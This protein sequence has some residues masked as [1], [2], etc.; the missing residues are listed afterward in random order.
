MNRLISLRARRTFVAASLGLLLAH[1]H[2]ALS[3]AT[4]VSPASWVVPGDGTPQQRDP[5][6]LFAELATHP[7]VLLGERHDNADHHRWQLHTIAGLYALQPDLVIGF[8]MFPRRVQ[9]ALDQWV[10]G[11]LSEDEFLKRSEWNR[12]WGVDARPYMPIFEFARLHR[13][14]MLALNVE[15]DLVARVGAVG[16]A[17]IPEPEREGVSDP[18]APSTGYREA[19]YESY[20]EHLPKEAPAR[21]RAEPDYDDPAFL[22]FVESMQLWDRAMAQA[23]AQRRSG[24]A[25][26]L[27]VAIMGSGHLEEGFGVP[28]QLRDLGVAEPAVLL[29][30]DVDDDCSTLTVGLAD[31][32]FGLPAASTATPDR[33]RLGV[34]L[35][36]GD[37]S[38]VVR[39][40]VKGSVAEQAGMHT[41]DV[42]VA[43]AGTPVEGAGDIINAVRQ[44]APGT[45]LP[46]TVK[47]GGE[48]L[49]LVARFP[50]RR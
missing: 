22:R 20:L 42:I 10:V 43:V 41:G 25:P 4:C 9:K 39:D 14:P 31:A 18:A 2:A 40:V 47:R 13:V 32:V 37:G 30:W 36:G 1:S 45:W 15:R 23:I 33:P 27:V 48:S 12:V 44:Q 35:D 38:V 49:E 17:G 6:A 16:W 7:V 50:P 3:S 26:P 29:P 34:M 5:R 46:M 19:L 24:A 28:H 11:E 8:E 21:S